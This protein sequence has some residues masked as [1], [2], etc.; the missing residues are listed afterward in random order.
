MKYFHNVVL[1]A[2]VKPE[3]DEQLIKDAV[4]SLIPFDLKERNIAL[5]ET[6]AEGFQEKKIIILKIILEKDR[7]IN[8]FMKKLLERLSEAQKQQLIEQENR[9][10][11]H[12]CYYM[13]FD[14]D[15]LFENKL[16]LT[17]AGNC[18]HVKLSVA[19]FPKKREVALGV[20]RSL[21]EKTL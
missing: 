12:L 7:D 11:E 14:K 5:T 13:R 3:E 1:S 18:V 16:V 6:V 19:S 15:Y 2:F 4:L 17:D 10:D 21:F 20:I 8:E 9:L